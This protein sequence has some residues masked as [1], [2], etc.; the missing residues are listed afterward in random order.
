MFVQLIKMLLKNAKNKNMLI[1]TWSSEASCCSLT[2]PDSFCITLVDEFEC[3]DTQGNGI[4]EAK[5]PFG[6]GW[7]NFEWTHGAGGNS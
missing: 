6:L 1:R 7:D 3:G 2:N 5:V 4:L